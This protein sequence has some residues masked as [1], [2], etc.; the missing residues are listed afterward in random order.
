DANVQFNPAPL[1]PFSYG[2]GIFPTSGSYNY[3]GNTYQYQ[4]GSGFYNMATFSSTMVVTGHAT[5]WVKS[6]SMSGG[7]TIYIA[8]GVSL[9]IY[10]DGPGSF[11]GNGIANTTG[12]AGSCQ[13]YGS[14]NCTSITIG[15]NNGYT[16]TIY[17]PEADLSI[18]G[19]GD[20]TGAIT[21]NTITMTG[22]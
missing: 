11:K 4:L 5:F 6:V 7:A 10:L 21:A 1:P 13:I 15:G 12:Y 2:G 20:V 19:G 18:G 16:G 8:P 17:A 3:S 9:V 14:T 22:T